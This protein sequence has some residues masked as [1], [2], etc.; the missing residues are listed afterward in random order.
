V[1]QKAQ[2][3]SVLLKEFD[4]VGIAPPVLPETYVVALENWL[5][6]GMNASM[7][8]MKRQAPTR[9]DV[10]RALPGIESVICV[11]LN[12]FPGNHPE[13]I[14]EDFVK[15][16]RYAW[17]KDYHTVIE[18]K[19]KKCIAELSLLF[20]DNLFKP[21]VDYGPV[22]EKAYAE[23]S[24]IGFIGKNGTIITKEF[25]SWVFLSVILTNLQLPPD[26]PSPR[27]CGTCTRCLDACP[28]KAI[29]RPGVIDSRLCISFQTIENKEP[30]IPPAVAEKLSGWGFGCDICQEVCPHN[31]RAKVTN[32]PEF[33]DRKVPK[34]LLDTKIIADM[35]E[36]EFNEIF[37]HS[38]LKRAKRSG[39]QRNCTAEHE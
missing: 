8:Y 9:K 32:H 29:V 27:R 4:L 39:L 36:E 15:V 12:Y 1:D 3:Q 10:S 23:L 18:E 28:T 38:P 16:S 5:E 37:H 25:G 22:Q 34:G 31:C 17:G 7:A 2:V 26:T 11:A 6:Q 20:P 35:S 19:S 21:Y 14:S 33:L 24:G 13:H 30:Q